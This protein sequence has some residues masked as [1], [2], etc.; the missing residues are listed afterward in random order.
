[1]NSGSFSQT[2]AA[3]AELAKLIK[4]LTAEEAITILNAATE[5]GQISSIIS[6]QDVYDFT[7]DLHVRHFFETPVS[8][9]AKLNELFRPVE[10]RLETALAADP[11]LDDDVPF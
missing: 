11:D 1:M 9:D 2:H 8:L 5:N 10:E 3:V 7:R 6:D 4:D